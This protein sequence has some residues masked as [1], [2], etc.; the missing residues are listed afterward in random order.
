M[1]TSTFTQLLSSQPPVQVQC[2]FTST[3]T[4]RTII[5]GGSQNVHF[6]F[7]TAPE[8]T[9]TS[10]SSVLLYV[11]RDHEDNYRRGIP[12]CPPQLSHSS[13]V[14]S[15]QFK[16]GATLRPQRPWGLLGMGYPRM[17][18]ST[19][20][21][22]LSSDNLFITCSVFTLTFCWSG[23]WGSPPFL[24]VAASAAAASL[25]RAGSM[26]SLPSRSSGI[27]IV[28]TEPTQTHKNPHQENFQWQ[29]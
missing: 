25:W 28:W 20:T 26:S 22:R 7:H 17:S 11:H 12:E 18:T 16:F 2:Y 1:S 27:T 14:H 21:Q 9:A 19:F 4:M 3:E 29:I 13:W 23:S 15:H 6:N 24:E 10:S 8:F 5:D